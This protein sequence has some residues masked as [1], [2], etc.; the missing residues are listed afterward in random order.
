MWNYLLESSGCWIVLYGFY[1]LL[2]RRQ[3]TFGYNR[4]Y[5]LFALFLGLLVPLLTLEDR[6][7]TVLLAPID[8][9][10]IAAPT[11]ANLEQA[12]GSN[13]NWALLIFLYG[14]GLLVFTGRFL[15]G[16]SRIWKIYANSQVTPQAGYQ[17]VTMSENYPPFSFLHCLFVPKHLSQNPTAYQCILTHEAAHIQQAHS[18]DILMIE[19]LQI[20]FWFNPILIFYKMALRDQHEYLAD[21]AVLRNTSVAQYGHLLLDQSVS[22]FLPLV[23]PF[24]HSSLK[25]RILMMTNTST[26]LPWSN[27]AFSLLAFFLT[28]WMIACQKPADTTTYTL[29][30]EMPY[31]ASCENED[32]AEQKK[33][34]NQ[35]LLDFVYKEVAYPSS[36]KEAGAE[37]MAV[38]DFIVEKDGRIGDIQIVR[39]TG[40]AA[41]DAEGIRVLTQLKEKGKLWKPGILEGKVVRTS[42][43]LPLRFKLE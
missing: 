39:S 36:A 35:T 15:W 33:C 20:I 25:K 13:S 21:Q 24:F 19:L 18:L 14:T 32:K 34:S 11:F 31:L 23:H 28:F 41:L 2:L 29:P 22:T 9:A 4:F 37:G 43:K 26:R 17:L 42:Y 30:D 40:N 5:L 16:L 12:A 38:L 3:K 1:A 8:L 27:Y 7:A 6:V 10:A